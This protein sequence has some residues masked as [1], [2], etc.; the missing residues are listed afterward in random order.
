MAELSEWFTPEP[1]MMIQCI[2]R[3][4][5]LE[6]IGLSEARI[7]YQQA[8]GQ[9]PPQQA[10]RSFSPEVDLEKIANVLEGYAAEYMALASR[11]RS[12]TLSSSDLEEIEEL[13]EGINP[14]ELESIGNKD[15]E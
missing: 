4:R 13:M 3:L 6:G 11:I 10:I 14:D 12:N 2:K 7:R 8:A 9:A 5:E 1:S 15:L